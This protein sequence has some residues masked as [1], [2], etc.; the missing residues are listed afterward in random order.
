MI[1]EAIFK[2]NDRLICDGESL[3]IC[4]CDA[5]V[6]A[7]KTGTEVTGYY[8]ELCRYS[9]LVKPP[10]ASIAIGGF[11]ESPLLYLY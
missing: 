9:R 5:V 1:I 8:A 10:L 11:F 6:Y 2:N 3:S 4:L 7:D